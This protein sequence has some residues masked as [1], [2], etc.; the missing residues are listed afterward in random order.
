MY[1][2]PLASLR[3]AAGGSVLLP[4]FLNLWAKGRVCWS[5]IRRRVWNRAGHDAVRIVAATVL[6]TAAGLKAH[7]LATEPFLGTSMLDSRWLLGVVVESELLFGLWLLGNV[8]PRT[9]WAGAVGLFGL[10]AGVSL[11]KALAGYAACGCFGRVAVNPWY[12]A[13]LDLALVLAL[14]RRRPKTS[15]FSIRRAIA[16]VVLWLLVGVPA[17]Y[18]MGG[19]EAAILSEAGEVVGDGRVVILEP[20]KWLGKR[21]P[22]LPYIEDYPGPRPSGVPPL[23]ERLAVGRWLIV[24]YRPDCP[25]CRA[26]I[27]KWKR[28][29]R[30][31]VGWDDLPRLALLE[32]PPY[33]ALEQ[34]RYF[35]G[36]S[37][38]SG[39]IR[40]SRKWFVETPWRFVLE[41][42]IVVPRLQEAQTGEI[43][44]LGID[45]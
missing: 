30:E 3:A 18:V 37:Y 19:Y 28:K 10:F 21:F 23:R 9:S 44:V 26:V 8:T 36:W 5:D 39:R 27:F 2:T 25:K 43:N 6:L 24:L 40:S 20:E 1:F 45:R 41:E 32:L 11:Y 12:T 7:Q 31:N 14:L 38:E 33:D 16:I 42:G 35:S 29:A 34:Q 4:R 15:F 17:A 22:L 13:A